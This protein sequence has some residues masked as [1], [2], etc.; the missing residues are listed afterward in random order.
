MVSPAPKCILHIPHKEGPLT[1]EQMEEN[2]D[3]WEQWFETILKFKD[4]LCS[5]C[6]EH[7]EGDD[8]PDSGGF[9]EQGDTA[10]EGIADFCFLHVPNKRPK[11]WIEDQDNLD[12]IENHVERFLRECGCAPTVVPLPT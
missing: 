3:V 9:G 7:N 1:P 2:Y 4:C 11:T 10:P 5:Q 8:L 12:H 6:A